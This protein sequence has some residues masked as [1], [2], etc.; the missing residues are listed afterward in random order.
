MIKSERKVAHSNVDNLEAIQ[1]W[2]EMLNQNQIFDFTCE[3][4]IQCTVSPFQEGATK[5][6]VVGFLSSV[7][8]PDLAE[9]FMV[10][11]WG[12]MFFFKNSFPN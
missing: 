4:T 8:D 7:I 2:S 1:F 5:T 6:L 3:F 10:T 11:V 12:D 9:I